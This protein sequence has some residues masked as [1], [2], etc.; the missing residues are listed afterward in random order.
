MDELTRCALAA[1][2]GDQAALGRFVRLSQADVWRLAA[3]LVDRGEADDITQE[4]Y[5]RALRSLGNYRGE[6]S[7][8]TW[9]LTIARRTCVDA[10]RRRARVRVR[11][12]RLRVLAADRAEHDLDSFPLL[13]EE[14]LAVL[15]PDRRSAFVLTQ[16][17][18]YGYAEAA[19]ICGCPVGTIRS[20]VARAR[21][22]L[23]A[24]W[25]SDVEVGQEVLGVDEGDRRN[26]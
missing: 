15:D 14:A 1:R 24:A 20:R 3:H 18:G 23:M 8:R 6:A 25:E 7:A 22:E 26:A 19:E 4:V 17:L 9:L 16:L 12:G 11:D 21:A 5:E 2:D 10:I 13:V